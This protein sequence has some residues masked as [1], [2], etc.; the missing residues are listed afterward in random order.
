MSPIVV[1]TK[2]DNSIRLC[3]DYRRIDSLT[4][5]DQYPIPSV[6]EL[7]S[8]IPRNVRYIQPSL[9]W[10][11][12][13]IRKIPYGLMNAPAA[14]TQILQRALQPCDNVIVY[15]DDILSFA[16]GISKVRD[17]KGLFITDFTSPTN[18]SSLFKKTTWKIVEMHNLLI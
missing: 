10:V 13:A 1:T 16:S 2:R 3:V 9:M 7:F 17:A 8:K 18:D 11:F 12:S 6:D 4:I 15:F 5:L 14:F